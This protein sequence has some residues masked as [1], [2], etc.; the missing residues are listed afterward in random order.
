[1]F[2]IPVYCKQFLE[3]IFSLQ[4][5]L[6]VYGQVLY[7]VFKSFSYFLE[8]TWLQNYLITEFE[9]HNTLY[10]T[11]LLLFFFARGGV[12]YF[13]WAF[14]LRLSD[15]QGDNNGSVWARNRSQVGIYLVLSTTLCLGPP[16]PNK[17]HNILSWYLTKNNLF[18]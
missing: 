3:S 9:I 2:Y 5:I 11:L 16:S 4:N 6:S 10:I 8:C 15:L 13:L 12:C 18:Y 17:I 1:M 14:F 7:C